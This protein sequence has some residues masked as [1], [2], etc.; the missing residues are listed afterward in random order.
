MTN[1]LVSILI[2]CFNAKRW[3]AQAVESALAQ[4]WAKKEVIVVD[5]GSTDGSLEVIKRYGDCIRWETGPNSGGN[6]A[7]NRL[8]TLARGDWLQYL[9]ADD[10]LLPEKIANQVQFLAAHPEAEVIFGAWTMEHWAEAGS[11]RV[12]L[13]VHEPRD[14]WMLLA[15]W[16]LPQTGGPLWRRDAL[17]GVG[18]WNPE[19][20]CC[21][22]YEL[23]LRLLI[24]GKRFVYCPEAGAIYRQWGDHTVCKRDMPETLRRRL[25][26]VQ[27]AEEHLRNRGKLTPE[28]LRAI[29]QG[30]FESA[31]QAWLY[32]RGFAMEIMAVIRQSDPKFVPAE[33]AAPSHYQLMYRLFGFGAAERAAMVKRKIASI[34]R[35]TPARTSR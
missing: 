1:S 35:R 12:L 20:P 6:V 2:P 3:I 33:L 8:L 11:F 23:Y 9:D 26:I 14:P 28:R 16:F 18:G 27:R 29:S 25:E 15:R 4:T 24:A 17:V 22:E 34:A 5:D 10:Y 31:R 19:Q 21:Q 30:R 7:R 13:E 32:D